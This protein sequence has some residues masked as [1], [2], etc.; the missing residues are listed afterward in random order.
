MLLAACGR[1]ARVGDQEP[2]PAFMANCLGAPL[3][4]P[5]S[6]GDFS[7]GDFVA[8]QKWRSG[9]TFSW[10][11]GNE[12]GYILRQTVAD[13]L[14]KKELSWSYQLD[15]GPPEGQFK[16]CGPSL[17]VLSRILANGVEVPTDQIYPT[18]FQIVATHGHPED[19]A[20]P[21]PPKPAASPAAAGQIQHYV[22]IGEGEVTLELTPTGPGSYR[23]DVATAAPN[24][25]G[26]VSGEAID[27]EGQI[28]GTSGDD[29]NCKI[30]MTKTRDG[31]AVG[32]ESCGDWH[33]A[34]CA[35]DGELKAKPKG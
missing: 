1:V 30:Y 35:F 12:G 4:G 27:A 29:A 34:A 15:P 28:V 26:S 8:S 31:M 5:S 13:P 6:L 7:V 33:G 25:F 14:T 10:D 2:P 9:S 16:H 23:F 24:C 17:V 32:E 19:T 20:T 3:K 22:G 11:K 18:I 21:T